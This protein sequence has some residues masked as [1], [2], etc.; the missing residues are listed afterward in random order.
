M[1][2]KITFAGEQGQPRKQWTE[3]M[4]REQGAFASQDGCL[5]IYRP[6]GEGAFIS[7]DCASGS[8]TSPAEMAEILRKNS[9]FWRPVDVEIVVREVSS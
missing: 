4:V 1:I 6:L 8:A 2:I 5:R 7:P 3:E 9:G